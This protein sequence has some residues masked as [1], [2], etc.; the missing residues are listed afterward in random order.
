MHRSQTKLS[1]HSR[2]KRTLH[3]IRNLIHCRSLSFQNPRFPNHEKKSHLKQSYQPPQEPI[4]PLKQ[5]QFLIQH[6]RNKPPSQ[7]T[8]GVKAELLAQARQQ[9]P[10]NN[11]PHHN[12]PKRN[13]QSRHNPRNY[14][15]F[16]KKIS[17]RSWIWGLGEKKPFNTWRLRMGMWIRQRVCCFKGNPHSHLSIKLLCGFMSVFGV[18]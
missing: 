4:S 7:A 1:R 15:R 3:I 10:P 5:A 13:N 17:R 11:D 16:V 14:R 9:I 8:S 12:Q 2:Q 6:P 18:V